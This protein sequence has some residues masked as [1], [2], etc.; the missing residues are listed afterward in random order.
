M[1]NINVK[2]L[3]S[4][5]YSSRYYASRPGSLSLIEIQMLR[6]MIDQLQLTPQVMSKLAYRNEQKGLGTVTLQKSVKTMKIVGLR[7]EAKKGESVTV[8][9]T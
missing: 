4:V 3:L 6:I 1:P 5:R 2:F 9:I 7:S 8:A